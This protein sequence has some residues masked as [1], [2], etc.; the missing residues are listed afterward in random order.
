M[1]AVLQQR[2][3]VLRNGDRLDAEEFLR[4]YEAMPE[5]CKAELIGGIVYLGGDMASPV[6]AEDHGDPHARLIT[7]L[8]MYAIDTT[9]VLVSDNATVTLGPGDVPQPDG[10]MR[11]VHRGRTTLDRGY[12]QRGPELSAE[13]AASSVSIDRNAKLRAYRDEGI[14]EYVLWRT[15]DG[16]IDWFVLEAGQYVPLRPDPDGILRSRV[17][18]GLWLDGAAMVAGNMRRVREVLNLGVASPEHAAFVAARAAAER[19]SARA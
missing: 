8:G 11:I 15:E 5:K 1:T 3:P 6:N 16:A 10:S 13:V 7:W 19:E 17:F 12:I 2:I 18:P 14:P 9:G 4:R